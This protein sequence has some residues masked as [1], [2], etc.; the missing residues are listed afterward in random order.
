MVEA[1]YKYQI[2]YL[3]FKQIQ[4]VLRDTFKNQNLNRVSN[5]PELVYLLFMSLSGLD[6]NIKKGGLGSPF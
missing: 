6:V 5:K 4:Q 1:L 2:S 3:E